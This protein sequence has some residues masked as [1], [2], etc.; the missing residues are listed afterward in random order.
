MKF[1]NQI[2]NIQHNPYQPV[3]QSNRGLP[4]NSQRNLSN[5]Y[6]SKRQNIQGS[7]QIRMFNT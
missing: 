6:I 2:T 1:Y 4:E 3:N 7:R 5:G